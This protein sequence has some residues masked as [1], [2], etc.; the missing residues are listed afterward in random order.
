MSLFTVSSR[1]FAALIAGLLTLG[2]VA[3]NE[4]QQQSN[5]LQE[6]ATQDE[7][8][9][10]EAKPEAGKQEETKAG[11]DRFTEGPIELY[12]KAAQ[13]FEAREF[14]QAGV[15]FYAAQARVGMDMDLFPP[16]C[17]IRPR[18]SPGSSPDQPATWT[19]VERDVPSQSSTFS[20]RAGQ[21]R[22]GRICDR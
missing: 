8:K 20:Q 15:Y 5:R 9:Q 12:Q 16:S 11:T 14:E 13:S 22:K 10:V 21:S 3:G 2:W 18:C 1:L 17:R 19:D 4:A 7:T 6:E